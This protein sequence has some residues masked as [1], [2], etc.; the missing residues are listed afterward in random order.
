MHELSSNLPPLRAPPELISCATGLKFE[1]V[2]VTL[3]GTLL[4]PFDLM[5]I[6]LPGVEQFN[7]KKRQQFWLKM[8][9]YT[10]FCTHFCVKSTFSNFI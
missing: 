3:F 9:N 2:A 6:H 10:N 5:K 1:Y 8:I 7:S 4:E